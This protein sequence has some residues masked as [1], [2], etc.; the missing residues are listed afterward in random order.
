[1][2]NIVYRMRFAGSRDQ[3]R[4]MIRH[5]HVRVNNKKVDIPSFS[6][7]VN[8]KI[9][10]KEKSRMSLVVKESLKEYSRSGVAPWLW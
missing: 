9:E 3:A 7:K 8:D 4:Q 2:D 10:I 6:V 5:G 1:M